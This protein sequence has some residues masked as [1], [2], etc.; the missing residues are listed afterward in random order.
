MTKFIGMADAGYTSFRGILQDWVGNL[1]KEGA[2]G[3]S[4]LNSSAGPKAATQGAST[5]D[6]TWNITMNSQGGPQFRGG[7]F[8]VLP[9][10]RENRRCAIPY[11]LSYCPTPKNRIPPL[12]RPRSRFINFVQTLRFLSL[13]HG[14]Y[15]TNLLYKTIS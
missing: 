1:K 9:F 12:Y 4:N 5:A 3:L 7:T 13:L 11:Y 10:L 14:I 8:L 6:N 2:P 15:K